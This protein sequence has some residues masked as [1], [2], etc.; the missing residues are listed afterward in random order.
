MPR[1]YVQKVDR[2]RQIDVDQLR[3]LIEVQKLQHW[4]VAEI[5]ELPPKKMTK[6]CRRYDIKTQRTGPRGGEGHPEWKGGRT[7]CDGY[8]YIYCP[9][10]PHATKQHRVLEHRL[11]MERKLGRFLD[12]SEVVH[13][14][15]GNSQNNDP[16]N[17]MIFHTNATHLKHELN[18]RVPNWTPEGFANMCKANPKWLKND[19]LKAKYG[20]SQPSQPT[21]HQK[22]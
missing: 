21:D 7:L 12:P 22:E 10:H 6:F 2:K 18:G 5:M 17:L 19:R 3:N 15:D 4:K 20:D 1:K 8:W 16:E 14:I 13:H 9:D 11:V